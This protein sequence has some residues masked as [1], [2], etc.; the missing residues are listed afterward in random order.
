[1]ELVEDVPVQRVHRVHQLGGTKVVSKA[2]AG[3][4]GHQLPP[5]RLSPGRLGAGVLGGSDLYSAGAGAEDSPDCVVPVR[6]ATF[7]PAGQTGPRCLPFPSHG[8]SASAAAL[9]C[10]SG[11]S[12]TAPW[13]LLTPKLPLGEVGA[14]GPRFLPP[15][16][17]AGDKAARSATPWCKGRGWPV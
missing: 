6:P 17:A 11:L 5:T 8:S 16:G 12:P 13:H 2:C 14:Q 15:L 9:P 1:M 7:S 10:S 3:G 4:V